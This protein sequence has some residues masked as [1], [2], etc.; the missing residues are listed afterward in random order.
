[1][2]RADDQSFAFEEW[3]KAQAELKSMSLEDDWSAE[4]NKYLKFLLDMNRQ[5]MEREDDLSQQFRKQELE[6]VFASRVAAARVSAADAAK[7]AAGAMKRV[8]GDAMLQA[9]DAGEAAAAAAAQLGMGPFI[10]AAFA[11]A[12]AA[13][14]ASVKQKQPLS[15]VE[16]LDEANKAS[17]RVAERCGMTAK[18][19]ELITEA[20]EA[21][22][23]AANADAQSDIAACF[24]F[25][26][27][28]RLSLTEEAQSAVTGGS[29]AAG[30]GGNEGY[31]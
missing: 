21:A 16:Q 26:L 1:M 20:T 29:D 18:D 11:G 10:Q 27:A 3:S 4:V 30:A 5:C 9:R 28:S 12:Q 22:K 13:A 15:R 17:M 31:P 25:A 23:E 24:A 7:A 14:A 6:R 2:L 8:G 19:R